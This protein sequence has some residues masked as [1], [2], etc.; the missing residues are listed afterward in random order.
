MT[1]VKI[2]GLMDRQDLDQALA[3]GADAVGFVVEID[4][5]RH[6][7]SSEEAR[8][9]IDR[10][11]VFAKSVAVVAPGDLQEAVRL[12]R[13]TGA[14]LLQLHSPFSAR[15]I[16][17]L[18]R[19]VPQRI[20]AAT[21]PGS[22]DILSLARAADAILLDTFSDGVLGGSGRTHDWRASAAISRMLEVPVILA[23]G[24]DPSNVLSAIKEVRPYA[25][26]VSSGVETGGRKDASKIRAFVKQVRSCR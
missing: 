8:E 6:C 3:A 26:D 11:P 24:L 5:S 15:D 19:M 22:E 12:S 4:R 18:K 10:V 20:I 9:M 23:G 25:V 21:A 17:E 13:E 16:L 2:C 1:R 7:L 14:D